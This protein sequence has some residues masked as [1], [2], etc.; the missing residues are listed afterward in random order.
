MLDPHPHRLTTSPSSFLQAKL[1]LDSITSLET[2]SEM[3]QSLTTLPR[4]QND[5]YADLLRN[6]LT[7]YPGAHN[8]SVLR[9][10]FLWLCQAKYCLHVPE[11][12][13]VTTLTF[14]DDG[15]PNRKLIP[16]D[17]E[18]YC[19]RLGPFLNIDRR[20]LIPEINLPHVTMEE[21]LQGSV[22]GVEDLADF[23]IDPP[24]AQRELAEF[25]IRILG[26]SPEL[27]VSI[28]GMG[29]D[30]EED[31]RN[32]F[33]VLPGGLGVPLDPEKHAGIAP[34]RERLSE[35]LGLEYAVINWHHHLRNAFRM[36]ETGTSAGREKRVVWVEKVV[37]PLLGWFL[38]GSKGNGRY[39]SWCETHAYFCH[40][41]EE[42]C[43]CAVW[44]GPAYFAK[45]FRLRFL[46]PFVEGGEGGDEAAEGGSL[47]AVNGFKTKRRCSEC[48]V[49]VSFD[50]VHACGTEGSVNSKEVEKCALCRDGLK[51]L[52]QCGRS[53]KLFQSPELKWR[54]MKDL[55]KYG[56]SQVTVPST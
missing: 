40:D 52:G 36:M 5:T 19:L 22:R 50:N 39:R 1:H 8:R 43:G 23:N 7:H 28:S 54:A 24:E 30:L 3:E 25:C 44:R 12:V 6:I 55:E 34:M 35:C 45:I 27:E 56:H 48:E 16:W 14:S 9:R 18:A 51:P 31:E 32:P 20:P 49:P 29:V 13:A 37:V 15:I 26:S 53:F 2:V 46:L 38:E 42:D 47:D 4:K 41:L 17:A 11:F 21:F 33:K 10:M